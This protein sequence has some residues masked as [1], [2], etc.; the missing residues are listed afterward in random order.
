MFR[1]VAAD[2]VSENGEQKPELLLQTYRELYFKPP[3]TTDCDRVAIEEQNFLGLPGIPFDDVDPAKAIP[4]CEAALKAQPD[5]ARLHNN[6]ARAYEKA[7][8][9]N[10]ALEQYKAA[11]AAGYPPAINA[12]GIMYLSGCG[13]PAREVETGVR[14][15]A[16]ARELGNLSARATLT[17]HD[18]LPYVDEDGG[19]ATREVARAGGRL[20]RDTGR[21]IGPQ[22]ESGTR[23]LSEAEAASAKGPDA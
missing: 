19:Q 14:D 3:S 6:L 5:S 1:S 16:R 17:S 15:I 8:R 12:L 13:L 10:E 20:S 18:L 21:Q 4:A 23:K 2:V 7:E 11:A 22:A 9:L